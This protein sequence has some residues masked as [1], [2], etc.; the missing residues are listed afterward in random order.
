MHLVIKNKEL[1]VLIIFGKDEREKFEAERRDFSP[2]LQ[3]IVCCRLVL[4]G[5]AG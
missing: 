3:Q 2:Q 1:V 4:P 5:I